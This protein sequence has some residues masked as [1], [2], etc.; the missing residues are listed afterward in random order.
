MRAMADAVTAR[1]IDHIAS[2]PSQP[3]LGD[4]AAEDLCRSLREPAPEAGSALEPLLDLLHE[5]GL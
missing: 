2:L 5:S 4:V 3:I 1:C